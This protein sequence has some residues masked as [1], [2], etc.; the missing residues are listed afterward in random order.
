MNLSA[1]AD[2]LRARVAGLRVVWL[3]GSHA[4]GDAHAESD[5]DLAV[6]AD[7]PLGAEA[8]FALRTDLEDLIGVDVDLI[9]LLTADDVLRVQAIE[10]GRCL[11]ERSATDRARFEMHALSRYAHL[12]EERRGILEDVARRGSIR[13]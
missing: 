6:L 11:F 13:G 1:A 4:R 12:N 7:A 10:H 2:L 3:F 9:D 8:C 5:V